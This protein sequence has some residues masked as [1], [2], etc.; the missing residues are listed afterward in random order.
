[1]N[2]IIPMAGK[3]SRFPN[4]KPKWMLA[5]PS[6]NFMAIQA[7]SKLNLSDFDRIVFVAL[8]KHE[9]EFSFKQGFE[10]ELDALGI[11][12]TIHLLDSETRDVTETVSRTITDLN[13]TGPIFIKD[14]DSCFT[15][16]K[17]VACNSVVYSHLKNTCCKHP[18][19]SSY[20]T[21]DAGINR[22]ITNIVE[23]QIISPFICVGGY[24][25]DDALRFVEISKLLDTKSERY[26]SNVIYFDR[27]YSNSVYTG[28]EI[29]DLEDWGTLEDW[30]AYKHQFAT[31]FVDIDGVLMQHLSVHFPPYLYEEASPIESNI[32]YLQSLD[33]SKIQIILTTSRPSRTRLE[34]EDQLRYL[35]IKYD[36]LI[37]DLKHNQRILINDFSD[38]NEFPNCSAVNIKRNSSDLSTFLQPL[39]R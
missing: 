1:M 28:I 11:R 33:T 4:V 9:A 13:L 27:I 39:I 29:D 22:I 5:H 18:E 37:M 2:L 38:T 26:I 6:G 16:E 14:A 19:S 24:I 23:K 10:F 8:Q 34:T 35:G 3:S 15:L 17:T 32:Q 36:Q 25:F 21:L 12:A 7:I 30:K 31:L 20:I